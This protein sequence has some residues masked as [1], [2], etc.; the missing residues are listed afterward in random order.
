MQ[1]IQVYMN[2]SL[3]NYN[4]IIYSEISK[5]AIFIDPLDLKS[6]M[7]KARELELVPKYLLNTHH[8]HDHVKDNH[9]FLNGDESRVH[10]KL[11]DGEEFHLSLTEK[12]RAVNTPGHVKDHQCFLLLEND[13]QVGFISGD[14][15]FNAGIGNT[16]N[17]G[18][19]DDHFISTLKIN[20]LLKDHVRLYPSHDYLLTNLKFALTVD[21]ENKVIERLLK[22]R[23]AQNQNKEFI[24]TTMGEE[25]Q[26]N[27]FFRLK[28]L[29]KYN[30]F[31]TLSE[32][33]VFLNIR[34]RRDNF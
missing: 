12:I 19:L 5:E 2:N 32:K 18:N 25:R 26:I 34:Q 20:K 14:A 4:Y 15:V 24:N 9:L 31:N 30:E 8:H 13:K 29:M 33:E 16:K 22:K 1:V 11:E 27:P 10:L 21:I 17:G 28:E 23:E 7:P 6:T 3:R